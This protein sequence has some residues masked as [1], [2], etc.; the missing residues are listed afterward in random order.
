[1]R[2]T[3]DE[4]LVV[5]D[6][7]MA[8][9]FDV[10]S[11]KGYANTNM[12][13]IA[14]ELG[15]TR[16]PLYYHFKNKQNLY[17][18]AVRKHLEW[19]ENSYANI[20]ASDGDFFVTL[21]RDMKFSISY[22]SKESTLFFDLDKIPVLDEIRKLRSQSMVTIHAMKLK[23]VSKAVQTGVLH[24]NTDVAEFVEHIYVIYYGVGALMKEPLSPI[25]I[26]DDNLISTMIE[27][28]RIKYGKDAQPVSRK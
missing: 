19:K 20:L 11:T 27:G 23:F 24:K 22:Y 18:E 28:L 12:Q 25:R 5:I 8:K 1:M 13:D 17:K 7:V 26:R 14:N 21:N 10:F 2:K 16:N 6:R 15:V 3:S 9:A 4:T